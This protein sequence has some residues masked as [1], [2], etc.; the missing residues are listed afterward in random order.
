MSNFYNKF[1][2][3][4]FFYTYC[5]KLPCAYCDI[6]DYGPTS[7]LVRLL[8]INM[9]HNY[10]ESLI[11][12]SS[13]SFFMMMLIKT[14]VQWW[15]VNPD[16]FVS[17]R[18]FRINE[19]S[20]LLNRPS[21]QKRKSVP[22]LFVRISEISGLSEPGLTNHHCIWKYPQ[23]LW[24]YKSELCWQ[25][26]WK[27]NINYVELQVVNHYLKSNTRASYVHLL[28]DLFRWGATQA[29]IWEEAAE[30]GGRHATVLQIP[31]QKGMLCVTWPGLFSSITIYNQPI[32]FMLIRKQ[33]WLSQLVIGRHSPATAEL[34]LT[35]L[36][37]YTSSTKF[38]LRRFVSK[39]LFFS[40]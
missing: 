4:M 33:K 5:V 25:N 30:L 14:F 37:M 20:G 11:A 18:N 3:C 26:K 19:F 32:S 2:C 34:N 27:N 1:Q 31:G 36:D 9:E 40:L 17:G 15:I 12:I 39:G 6:W 13:T 8:E 23:W 10:T 28:V 29:S 21:V 22:A 16:T 38:V 7:W 24:I 35:K